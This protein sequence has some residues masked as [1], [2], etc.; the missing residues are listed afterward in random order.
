MRWMQTGSFAR[1]ARRWPCRAA[2]L[3]ALAG[4]PAAAQFDLFDWTYASQAGTGSGIVSGVTMFIAGPEGGD[5]SGGSTN[6]FTTVAPY[7]LTVIASY[8]VDNDDGFGP[9]YDDFIT[10]VDGVETVLDEGSCFGCGLVL[11]VP[12]GSVFGFGIRSTDCA[13]GPSTVTL[14]TLLIEP[15]KALDVSGAQAGEGFGSALAR[16]PDLDGD[17]AAEVLVG[18]PLWDAGGMHA[19]RAVVCS[20]QSGLPLRELLGEAPGEHLGAAVSAA[21]LDADGVD[22]LVVGV[23]FAGSPATGAV[24]VYSGA[25]GHLIREW[26]GANAADEF[27]QAVACVGDVDLDGV[28]DVL[29]GAP[30]HD[31]LGAN[32]GMVLLFSGLDGSELSTWV[33]T[34]ANQELGRAVAG[35]GD[36]TGD[37]VIDVIVGAP[38]A[39]VGGTDAGLARVF[40]GSDGGL[41]HTLQSGCFIKN[42]VQFGASV[43]GPGDIDG[44]GLGDVAVGSPG[45]YCNGLLASP[46]GALWIFSGQ[47]AHVLFQTNGP[48]PDET[49]GSALAAVGDVDGDG[50]ADVAVG[51][52]SQPGG[53]PG[54]ARVYAGAGGPPLQGSVGAVGALHGSALVGLGDIDLD[55]LDDFGVGAPQHV[56]AGAA[57]GAGEPPAQRGAVGRSRLRTGGCWS[58][59]CPRRRRTPRRRQGDDHSAG[60]AGGGAR[61]SRRGTRHVEGSVQGRHASPLPRPG[62]RAEHG[63]GGRGT[64]R[65][66]RDG[67]DALRPVLVLADVD[68]RLRRTRWIHRLVGAARH[69]ALT[70]PS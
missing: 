8:S 70:C 69:G 54:R 49:L 44:D 29:V 26:K 2:L 43:A 45:P 20:G 56:V 22:D 52:P 62:G 3:V 18:A 67:A 10:L 66:G 12:S 58:A 28:S 25:D 30:L 41:V 27:G 60:R 38:K 31:A 63:C 19:G 17:G 46:S 40:S 34:A 11:T 65:R 50:L 24:R 57:T 15:A 1:N 61:L 51:S 48:H 39:D 68:R 4:S 23:P 14:S 13:F 37:G 47:D 32:D 5:C 55:G 53:V 9:G 7:A 42:H 59:P 64:R 36:V 35:A 21:D 16:V 33:G 6:S